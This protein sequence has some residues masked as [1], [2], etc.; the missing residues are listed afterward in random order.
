MTWQ[1][2]NRL[3]SEYSQLLANDQPI[4]IGQ[5]ALLVNKFFAYR[6]I[7][8]R[9]PQFSELLSLAEN[10]STW[11][12]FLDTLLSSQEFRGRFDL[13][14]SGLRF[15]SDVN[16]FRFWF[17]SSDREMGTR[18]A[19]GLYEPETVSI[20]QRVVRPDMHCLDIGAQTGFYTCLMANLIGPGG[21]VN[22]FEPFNQSFELLETNVAE[23]NWED[24]VK[25]HNIAI[26]DSNFD[27]R[28][29]IASG[30]IV[31]DSNGSNIIKATKIDD[32]RLDKVDFCKI[33]I[34]GHEPKAIRG[35]EQLLNRDAPIVLTEVNEYWLN[36]AGS[37]ASEYIALLRDFQYELYKLENNLC[38]LGDYVPK[39]QLENINVLALPCNQKDRILH[40]LRQ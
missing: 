16:G 19:A 9:M 33:D 7:L 10:E 35:M 15:M 22:A 31:A 26:S 14:P 34:E 21:E 12:E 13:I 1:L 39:N 5:T 40:V 23:N 30:M 18:M 17:N 6:I 38:E 20:L 11:R 36:Q 32:I 2:H 28:V 8:G 37:S 3:I 29:G 4:E 27:I 25:I 24:R